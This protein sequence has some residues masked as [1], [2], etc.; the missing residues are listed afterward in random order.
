MTWQAIT[1]VLSTVNTAINS[2]PAWVIIMVCWIAVLSLII[3][4]KS[5]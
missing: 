5:R 4:I 3:T 1:T 2:L